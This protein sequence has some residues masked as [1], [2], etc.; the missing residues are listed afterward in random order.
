MEAIM[1]ID[2][3]LHADHQ[4]DQLAAQFEHWRQSRSHRGERI[5]QALCAPDH[6]RLC[7]LMRRA[8]KSILLERVSSTA[9]V[10]LLQALTVVFKAEFQSFFELTNIYGPACDDKGFEKKTPLGTDAAIYPASW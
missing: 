9:Y 6:M 2:T 5:P 1:K 7:W 8:L 4:L 10:G 3:P